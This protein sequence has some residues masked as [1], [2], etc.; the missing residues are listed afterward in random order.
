MNRATNPP[1][2]V[3]PLIVLIGNYPLDRQESMLR[4]R[5][6]LQTQLEAGGMATESIFPRGLVGLISRGG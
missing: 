1:E 4:F 5:D 6:L 3:P 2:S